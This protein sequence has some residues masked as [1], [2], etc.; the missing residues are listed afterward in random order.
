M[1]VRWSEAVGRRRPPV[2]VEAE[3]PAARQR[4]G[5]VTAPRVGSHDAGAREVGGEG[6]P[7]RAG[8][9]DP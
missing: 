8:R 4:L 1:P 5:H 3:E 9:E 2:G 7:G 6:G